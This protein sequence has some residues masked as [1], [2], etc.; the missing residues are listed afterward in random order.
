ME[1]YLALNCQQAYDLLMKGAILVDL[2][3]DMWKNGRYFAVNEVIDLPYERI[4]SGHSILPEDRF[5]IMADY[6][7]LKSKKTCQF[8]V[9]KGYNSVGYIIGG[10]VDWEK[11]NMP[12]RYNRSEELTGGCVCQL[13][14]RNSK[15]KIKMDEDIKKV[16]ILCTGNSCRSIMAEAIINEY[17]KGLW[18]AFSAGVNPSKVNPRAIHVMKEIGIDIRS[19]RSKSVIEFLHRDDLDLVIT[20][21]DNA[22]ESCPVFLKPVKTVHIG[23]EDPADYNDQPDEIAL[24]D[25]KKVRD[26]IKK[27]LIEFLKKNE[28]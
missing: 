22:K 19:Y 12:M 3:K 17:R 26:Q 1:K 13:K 18:Q 27:D 10:I 5:L 9:D 16:L 20:V 14:P 7:G 8:L 25:N 23:F 6:V 4:E 2:R 11:E 21:C 24:H 15:E 28:D